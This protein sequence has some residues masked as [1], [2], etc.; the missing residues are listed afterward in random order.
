MWRRQVWLIL[1]VVRTTKNCRTEKNRVTLTAAPLATVTLR[2]RNKLVFNADRRVGARRRD[3]LRS[4]PR[5]HGRRSARG[6][7]PVRRQRVRNERRG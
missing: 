2:L 3:S 1:S 7:H 4:R 5:R 6:G